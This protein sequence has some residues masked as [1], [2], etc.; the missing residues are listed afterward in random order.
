MRKGENHRK[1]KDGVTLTVTILPSKK[2]Q[3]P[4]CKEK[5]NWN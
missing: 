5:S 3:E 2:S 4:T 1:I